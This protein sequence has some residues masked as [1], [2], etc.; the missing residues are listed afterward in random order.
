MKEKITKLKHGELTEDKVYSRI[1]SDEEMTAKREAEE[2]RAKAESEIRA[3]KSS[4]K[5]QNKSVVDILAQPEKDIKT[6]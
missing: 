2:A 1:P 5:F 6:E 3:V 4:T